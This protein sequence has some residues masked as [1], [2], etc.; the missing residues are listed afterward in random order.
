MFDSSFSSKQHLIRFEHRH[1]VLD[2]GE[3]GQELLP[4]QVLAHLSD[5]TGW[6]VEYLQV[7]TWEETFSSV[8]V[9]SSLRG[10]K[11]GF[12]SLLKSQSRQAG[13]KA[14]TNFGACRDLQ[15]RKYIPDP[16]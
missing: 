14:T 10:G 9:I 11:G 4:T 8:R 12:G 1:F 5:C 13:A 15:G 2:D 7:V 6:P 16:K 3:G